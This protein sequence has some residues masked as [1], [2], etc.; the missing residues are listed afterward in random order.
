MTPLPH[1]LESFLSILVAIR[2]DNASDVGLSSSLSLRQ[3]YATALIRLVNGLVDPLQSGTYAR[4]ILSI[5]A[6]IGLPAWLVELRHAATHEDLPSLELLRDGAKEVS[7]ISSLL[8]SS[9]H[10]HT[11]PYPPQSLTWLLH[12]YFLPTLNP[13]LAS[14]ART[15]ASGS[16]PSTMVRPV[17]PL[18]RQYKSLLKTVSRDA[19]L[20]ARCA[21]D[22]S[23]VLREIER[24]LAEA[25]VA[26]VH[27]GEFASGGLSSSYRGRQA[28]EVRVVAA[29]VGDGDE[30]V[31]G[32][33]EPR[34]AW[35]LD[36]LCEALLVKGALVP[37]S[38]K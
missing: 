10:A 31:E 21:G 28:G 3:S 37:L 22:I 26:A 24:W 35:A 9:P 38:R 18:L 29:A 11:H 14:P 15:P 33:P 1:A 36:R 34:E 17:E 19:S 25:R 27:G 32:E 13:A 20:R 12:N 4:S 8:F 2:Q 6:Q 23:G 16:S 30:E 5:A 7:E